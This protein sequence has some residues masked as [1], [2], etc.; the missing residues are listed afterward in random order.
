M[1]SFVLPGLIFTDPASLGSTISQF[2]RIGC[3]I[4]GSATLRGLCASAVKLFKPQ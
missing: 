2:K 1:E 4:D 3:R